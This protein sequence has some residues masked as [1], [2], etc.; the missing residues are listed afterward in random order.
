MYAELLSFLFLFP[1]NY[2]LLA[3]YGWLAYRNHRRMLQRPYRNLPGAVVDGVRFWLL[4]LLGL[5]GMLVLSYL[6]SLGYGILRL[7]VPM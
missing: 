1:G 4:F 3:G 2:L 5:A 7:R 6:T